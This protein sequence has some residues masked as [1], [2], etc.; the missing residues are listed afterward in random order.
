[1]NLLL[2][3]YDDMCKE[4]NFSL[5]RRN[6]NREGFPVHEWVFKDCSMLQLPVKG[7]ILRV[8]LIRLVLSAV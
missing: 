3:V 2:L 1:M 8:D 7:D 4:K 6:V 5:S